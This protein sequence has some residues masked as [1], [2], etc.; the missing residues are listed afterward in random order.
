MV[1]ISCWLIY[2]AKQLSFENYPWKSF[3]GLR[4]PLL[5]NQKYILHNCVQAAGCRA[6]TQP[7]SV[8]AVSSHRVFDC[9]SFHSQK[10]QAKSFLLQSLTARLSLNLGIR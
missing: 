9:D 3:G 5:V 8:G 7:P 6:S 10:F 2:G 4:N 1:L